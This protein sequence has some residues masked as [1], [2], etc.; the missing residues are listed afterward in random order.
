MNLSVDR[1]AAACIPFACYAKTR[2]IAVAVTS[3]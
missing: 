2:F 3:S 1:A